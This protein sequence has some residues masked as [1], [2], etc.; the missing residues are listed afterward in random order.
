MRIFHMGIVSFHIYYTQL[1]AEHAAYIY[2]ICKE[3]RMLTGR[4]IRKINH[5]E[6]SKIWHFSYFEY[7]FIKRMVWFSAADNDENTV[8]LQFY[9]P[10]LKTFF[11]KCSSSLHLCFHLWKTR[12]FFS[13]KKVAFLILLEIRIA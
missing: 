4:K 1:H 10:Q 2:P 7:W 11:L 8:E 5:V 3:F 13:R 6:V 9:F 12:Y